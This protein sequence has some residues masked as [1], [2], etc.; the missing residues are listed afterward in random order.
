VFMAPDRSAIFDAIARGVCF[1]SSVVSLL[2]LL[3]ELSII[4]YVNSS[5]LNSGG[6]IVFRDTGIEYVCM[7]SAVSCISENL[8]G[9]VAICDLDIIIQGMSHG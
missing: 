7:F 3:P 9:T 5:C 6:L 2:E 1:S 8:V 4:T